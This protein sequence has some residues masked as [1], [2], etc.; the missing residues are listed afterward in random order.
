MQ[1]ESSY[2]RRYDGTGL[3][4]SL[5]NRIVELHG[6]SVDVESEVGRGSRFTVTLPWK[7]AGNQGSRGAGQQ[8]KVISSSP[9]LPLLTGV[10]FLQ[11]GGVRVVKSINRSRGKRTPAMKTNRNVIHEI[12]NEGK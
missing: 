6:G 9:P 1:V 12:S 7:V 4:L 3:G 2:T 10:G 5:V 11:L 8:G